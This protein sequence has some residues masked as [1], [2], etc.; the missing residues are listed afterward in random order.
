M[1]TS[2]QEMETDSNATCF[3]FLCC[4]IFCFDFGN[5]L[6]YFEASALGIAR[7]SLQIP[8]CILI[9]ALESLSWKM[10]HNG[11]M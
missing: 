2:E 6:R 8:H 9:F 1:V 7:S 5:A 4:D 11:V 3:R 10:A